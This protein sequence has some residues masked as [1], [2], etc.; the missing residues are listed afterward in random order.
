MYILLKTLGD[1]PTV[2]G[3]CRRP[4]PLRKLLK[5]DAKRI[6]RNYYFDCD[7]NND[8]D[9][10]R[11]RDEK[12]ASIEAITTENYWDDGDEDYLLS[13]EIFKAAEQKDRSKTF[14]TKYAFGS[15]I[16]DKLEDAETE[17]DFD[18]I[19]E[20]YKDTDSLIVRKF[21]TNAEKCAYIQGLR[22]NYGNETFCPIPD[23][24]PEF[25]KYLNKHNL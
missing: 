25:N 21:D 15:E 6:I 20:E 24:Y 17:D 5:T 16:N 13:Y 23:E 11:L 22:D 12:L 14:T 18:T 2:M 19:F 3:V 7:K 1:E 10:A 9:G 4:E 8:K